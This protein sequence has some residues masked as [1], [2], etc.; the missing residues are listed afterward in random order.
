MNKEKQTSIEF[1]TSAAKATQRVN[2]PSFRNLEELADDLFEVESAKRS[3]HLN[4]PI[5]LGF[6]ILNY[7]K[8]RILQFYYDFLDKYIDRSD[9]QL[10]EMDTDSLYMS[11][12]AD[13]IDELIRPELLDAYNKEKWCW[14]PRT[15]PP[16]AARYDKRTPG[17][18][19]EE[20]RGTVMIALASKTYVIQDE[21]SR[22]CKLSCKGA[23]KSRVQDPLQLYKDVLDTKT[24][25]TATNTGFR[26]RNGVIHTYVQKRKAFAY[27][28][29]KRKVLDD[30]VST[31]VLDI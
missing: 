2:H 3:I 21:E 15:S 12:S 24:P 22:K 5:Q 30:G 28:Y 9:F 16:E 10:L 13:S 20:F 11:L 18:F 6:F 29:F 19:K 31:E 1:L 23:M 17:L 14:L 8:L 26:K 7:A 4:M 27:E 25:K